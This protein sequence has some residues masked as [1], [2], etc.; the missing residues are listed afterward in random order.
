M[1]ERPP[2]PPKSPPPNPPPFREGRIRQ[3]RF[4]SGESEEAVPPSL[5][6]GLRG[7]W[8]PS[9][10]RRGLYLHALV[11]LVFLGLWTWKLLEPNPVPE[12]ISERLKG[13]VRVFAAKSLHAGAYAFLTVLAVTLPVPNYWRWFLVGLLALHGVATEIGQTFVPGRDGQRSRCGHRL[14]EVAAG[15]WCS[16]VS[17]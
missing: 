16:G 12:A 13:D 6:R 14:G 4:A 8:V 11:F 2:R 15:L 17:C 7:E 1:S 3:P 5:G 10:Q 9:L